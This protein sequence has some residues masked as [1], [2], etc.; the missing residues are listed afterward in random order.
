MDDIVSSHP[1]LPPSPHHPKKI[2]AF[3]SGATSV[4]V[5]HLSVRICVCGCVC[6]FRDV[7]VFM[8]VCVRAQ[9]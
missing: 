5:L 4:S 8:C 9:R 1:F 3:I 7:H 2:H 6:L